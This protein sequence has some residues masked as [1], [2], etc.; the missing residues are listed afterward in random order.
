MSRTTFVKTVAP[1]N[2]DVIVTKTALT[3]G[4]TGT[5]GYS[6]TDNDKDDRLLFVVD[7]TGSATGPLTIYPGTFNAASQGA[8]NVVVGGGVRKS[9][10]VE[11]A[12][13][14]QADG[15]IYIGS[16]I[17]GTISAIQV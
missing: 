13:V 12:R 7:N 3:S 10:I 14:A 4:L 1:T 2:S 17:T 15:S 16:G 5:D 11:G 9:F 8:V 6:L